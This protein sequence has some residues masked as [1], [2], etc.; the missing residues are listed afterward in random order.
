VEVTFGTVKGKGHEEIDPRN[1]Y[2]MKVFD[3]QFKSNGK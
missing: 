2:A 1:E 3:K